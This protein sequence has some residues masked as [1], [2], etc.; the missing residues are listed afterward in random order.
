MATAAPAA[1]AAATQAL[2]VSSNMILIAS[3]R[4]ELKRK[5]TFNLI[6]TIAIK[7]IG[8]VL[9]SKIGF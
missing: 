3:F 5:L 1:P 4:L 7:E 6:F 9:G 8:Q 2:A